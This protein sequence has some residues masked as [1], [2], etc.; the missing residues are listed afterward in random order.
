MAQTLCQKGEKDQ[1]ASF[2]WN[3]GTQTQWL[4]QTLCQKGE[5]DQKAR[6]WGHNMGLIN[7]VDAL[8]SLAGM[9]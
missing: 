9:E 5:K 4:A 1:K 7:I 2:G 6:F 3:I 8:S